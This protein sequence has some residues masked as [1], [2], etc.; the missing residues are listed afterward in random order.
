MSGEGNSSP[1][2]GG[3]GAAGPHAAE[4]FALLGHET[5]LSILLALWEEYN[6]HAAD[7]AVPFSKIFD[8][9]DH[10]DRGNVS[11][12]LKK[13][14]GQ[15]VEQDGKRAGYELRESGHKL[16]RAVIAGAGVQDIELGPVEVGRVCPFCGASTTISYRDG[17]VIHACSECEGA[18]ERETRTEGFLSAV[19]FDP[20]GLAGRTPAEVR[21]A[22]EVA[23]LRQVQ[24]LFE[25][26]CP[27]CSGAVKGWL[28]CCADHDP[29]GSCGT[30]G[31]QFGA[32]A[33]FRCRTCKNHSTASPKSLALLHPAVIAFY[34][35]RGVS[36]EVRADD[37]E[38]IENLFDLIDGH[39]VK[40]VSAEPPV[41]KVWVSH[42]DGSIRVTF[43][44][45]AKVVG[46]ER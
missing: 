4:A 5:R 33:R 44:E 14:Q 28:E 10:D 13:L 16:V 6:P 15:F 26:V 23:A 7:N 25:G 30:C 2:A 18:A 32:W 19:P 24:S 3:A 12:H 41:A 20:A 8:R 45:E 27:S 11:Y 38:S 46:V 34:E 36:T 9:V 37:I 42:E 35:S 1:L 29:T 22:A 39:E 43:D 31:K 40:V 21:A 17:V